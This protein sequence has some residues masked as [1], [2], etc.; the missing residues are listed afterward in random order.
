MN[1]NTI[2][3]DSLRKKRRDGFIPV[4]VDFK[5]IS[6]SDGRLIYAEDAP[7]LALELEAAGAPA[8]SVV[9]ER[10]DFG[11]SL[12]MLK[13]V[14]QAVSIP[15]LRKDFIRTKEE[16]DI[17]V[18][19]GA[20]AV[21][22][23]CSVMSREDMKICYE[24]ALKKGI[25][26]LVETHNE[27]EMRLAKELGAEFIGI[28]NRDILNLEKDGGTVS[29]TVGILKKQEHDKVFY[30]SE[31]GLITKEDVLSAISAG[32]DGVLIGTGIWKSEDPVGQLRIFESL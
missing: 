20:K 19:C 30:I 4:V 17:S 31:S 24:Y 15:V 22:L 11:G 18:E 9:T 26:P 16:I 7:R 13:S 28:N 25:E 5:C 14:V 12:E 32:A 23:M 29:R 3:T 27:E 10:N 2:F 21:L 8:I 1:T 6:P